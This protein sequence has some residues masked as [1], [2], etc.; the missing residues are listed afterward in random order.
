MT[1]RNKIYLVKKLIVDQQRK[2]LKDEY[3]MP[4]HVVEYH[5]EFTESML[6][7]LRNEKRNHFINIITGD[8]SWFLF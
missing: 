2:I 5:A 7:I 6:E 8:E 3:P 1:L 4:N